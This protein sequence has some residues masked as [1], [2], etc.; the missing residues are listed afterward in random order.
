MS[1]ESIRYSDGQLVQVGDRVM[2]R[3][4]LRRSLR[5]KVVFTYDPTKPVSPNGSNEYGVSIRL[6][7][8]T[9]LWGVPGNETSLIGRSE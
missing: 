8:G 7:D 5:G 3:R 1:V 6:E 4:R 9:E 2:V